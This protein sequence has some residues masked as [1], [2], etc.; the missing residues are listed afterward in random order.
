MQEGD[1]EVT[2]VGARGLPS[3]NT[4]KVIQYTLCC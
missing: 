1:G 3:T 2:V 4:Y